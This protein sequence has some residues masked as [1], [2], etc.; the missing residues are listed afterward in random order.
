MK[1]AVWTIVL[2]LFIGIFLYSAYNLYLIYAETDQS[3]K[4]KELKPSLIIETAAPSSSPVSQPA[5]SPR[6][7]LDFSHLKEVN[8]DIIAWLTI[9]GTVIDYPVCQAGNNSYYLDHTASREYNKLGALFLDCHNSP[10]FSDFI[11]VI[12]GHN[13]K[14]GKMFAAVENFKE[15]DFFNENET[16]ILYT[17]AATYNLRIISVAVT[18][19]NSDYYGYTGFD[20]TLNAD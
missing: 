13:I 16:G 17:P 7:P 2:V 9:D 12:Y 8:E 5:E 20:E 18:K 14:T 4:Q 19:G 11:S 6:Q 3:D 15:K 10:D 1:K